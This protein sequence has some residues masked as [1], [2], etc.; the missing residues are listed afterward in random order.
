M[1]ERF[2]FVEAISHGRH[3]VKAHSYALLAAT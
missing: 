1:Q 3:V 2:V